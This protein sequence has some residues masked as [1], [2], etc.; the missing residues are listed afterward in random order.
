[1]AIG[2]FIGRNNRDPTLELPFW[3]METSWI[4][5]KIIPETLP[6]IIPGS[7]GVAEKLGD[8]ATEITHRYTNNV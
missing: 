2:N 3:E 8:C 5:Y 4:R 6:N 7:T 1:M